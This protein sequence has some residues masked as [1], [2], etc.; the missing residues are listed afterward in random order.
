MLI[1]DRKILSPIVLGVF[2]IKSDLSLMEMF[3]HLLQL[4]EVLQ[5]FYQFAAKDFFFFNGT[6]FVEKVVTLKIDEEV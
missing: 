3:C 1:L 5:I 6:L 4:G 2:K